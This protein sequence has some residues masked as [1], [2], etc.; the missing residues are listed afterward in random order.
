MKIPQNIHHLDQIELISSPRIEMV[1]KDNSINILTI[2]KEEIANTTATNVSEL[3]QQIAGIDIRRRGAEG[4]Q[5]DLYIRGGSFDQTLLFYYRYFFIEKY[6][7]S[8]GM[9]NSGSSFLTF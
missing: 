7:S 4:M 8:S 3:L 9:K 1:N 2:S 6:Y 5:A